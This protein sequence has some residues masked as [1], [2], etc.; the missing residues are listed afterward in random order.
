MDRD[1]KTL[2]M[3]R[4]HGGAGRFLGELGYDG[5]PYVVVVR[6]HWRGNA[7]RGVPGYLRRRRSG[8]RRNLNRN[9]V[10]M[11]RSYRFF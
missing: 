5:E 11:W 3:G 2:F 6:G 1:Y 4:R 9:R 7:R 10:R 8:R